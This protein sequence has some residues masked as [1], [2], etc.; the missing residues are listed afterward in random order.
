MITVELVWLQYDRS[1]K[2]RVKRDTPRYGGKPVQNAPY[3]PVNGR[4]GSNG[5]PAIYS[6]NRS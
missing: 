5:K 6:E 2:M 3:M 1:R 4:D